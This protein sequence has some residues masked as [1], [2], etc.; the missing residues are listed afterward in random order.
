[1]LTHW[2]RLPTWVRSRRSTTP[3]NNA[4]IEFVPETAEFVPGPS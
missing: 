3:D 2:R 1:M 4:L